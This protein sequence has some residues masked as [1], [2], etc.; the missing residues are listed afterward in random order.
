LRRHHFTKIKNN[1]KRPLFPDLAAWSGYCCSC[2][3]DDAT[4]WS[5]AK[6]LASAVPATSFAI[7]AGLGESD[8]VPTVVWRI[9]CPSAP[10]CL[11]LL[12]K[13]VSSGIVPGE[14]SP[15]R[16]SVAF[17]RLGWLPRFLDVPPKRFSNDQFN[18]GT[19][20]DSR[21]A[22]KYRTRKT[23]GLTSSRYRVRRR[24]IKN[25]YIITVGR[26]R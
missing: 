25:A 19:R 4:E 23:G 21:W 11:C 14:I 24:T 6:S 16:R 8:E 7:I 12:N 15:K 1:T 22:N 3:H 9:R 5:R 18:G 17:K 26:P 13:D 10:R 2:G 20:R